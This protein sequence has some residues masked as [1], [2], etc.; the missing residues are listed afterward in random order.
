MLSTILPNPGRGEVWDIDFD[1]TVGAEIQKTRPAV[2]LSINSI[3]HLPIKLVAPNH[4]L[5]S[6]VFG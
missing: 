1:L 3:G 4:G 5:A 6:K 2:V